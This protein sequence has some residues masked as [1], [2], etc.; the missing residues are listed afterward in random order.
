MAKKTRIKKSVIPVP[1]DLDEAINFLSIIAEEQRK[2]DAKKMEMN[3][4]IDR[5]KEQAI[6]EI[7]PREEKIEQLFDGL[8][9]FAE[10]NRDKLTEDGKKKTVAVPT[11]SFGWRMTPPSVSISK[12]EEVV[13]RL[14]SL[15]LERFIRIK[16]EVDKEA[17]LKEQEMAKTVSGVTISQHEEFFAKPAEVELEI[18]EEVKK[19]KKIIS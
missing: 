17:M 3:S 5:L 15:K 12:A 4:G 14:K 2:I 6:A 19:L 1:K 18:S 13:K 10:A 11:G 8:F 7:K 9:S 16:E